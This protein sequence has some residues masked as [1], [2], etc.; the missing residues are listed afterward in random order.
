MEKQI[1]LAVVDDHPIVRRGIV[2]TFNEAE[3]FDVVAE[4]ASA[5]EAVS[6]AKDAQPD[7]MLL[8][9]SMPGGGIEAISR[10]H[11][12]RPLLRVLMLSVR[13]DLSTVRAALKAGANG[14]VSKGIG[15]RDLIASAKKVA[16]GENYVDSELAAKLLLMD[17]GSPD[18]RASKSA[19]SRPTLSMR[20]EQIFRLLGDGLTNAEIADKLQLSENTVKH[21]ITPLLHKLGL[22][23]RTQAALL[24]RDR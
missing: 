1:R 9:V 20:E 6:I 11:Q 23:S 22:R 7:L 13:E 18:P 15:A 2:E 21:Y 24:A 5:E 16:A 14:Y 17:L 8:D 3:N 10:I 19:P 4:G 12:V